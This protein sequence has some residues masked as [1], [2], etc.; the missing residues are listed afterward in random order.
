MALRLRE[1]DAAQEAYRQARL[2]ITKLEEEVERI[3]LEHASQQPLQSGSIQGYVNPQRLLESQRYQM[4][5]MQQ[6]GQLR[7]Q[8]EMVTVESEKRRQALVKREQAVR[9][10]EKLEEHQRAEWE[11]AAQHRAQIVLDEWAAF[12]YWRVQE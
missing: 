3:L 10:L 12:Q 1:R 2:A 5:L 6:V 8:I 9:S 7:G 11:A 4:H